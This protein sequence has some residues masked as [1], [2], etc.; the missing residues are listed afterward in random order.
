MSPADATFASVV[1]G[2]GSIALGVG[3]DEHSRPSVG[4]SGVGSSNN[5]PPRV[6]PQAGKVANDGIEAEGNM[7]PNVLQHDEAGS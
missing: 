2:G 4:G 1:I 6:I 7:P 3:N 5:S